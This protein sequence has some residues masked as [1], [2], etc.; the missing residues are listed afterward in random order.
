MMPRF[1]Q[2]Y[3]P[4]QRVSPDL[5]TDNRAIHAAVLRMPCYAC[6]RPKG[7][8]YAN[9]CDAVAEATAKA[10]LEDLK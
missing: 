7:D 9:P 3:P 8:C 5:D 2:N 1:S 6:G 10:V 4:F